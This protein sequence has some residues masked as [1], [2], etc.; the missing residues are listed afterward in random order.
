MTTA[1]AASPITVLLVEDNPGDARL[2]LELL[3][4]VQ[5]QAFDLERVERL[6]DALT[7]LSRTGV[8]VVLLDLGLPDSQGLETFMRA[9]RG[10]PDEPIVVISG[11]DDERLALEAVRSGAQDYLVKGRIEGHLL[12][13]VLRY[14]GV[15]SGWRR[16]DFADELNGTVSVCLRRDDLDL[17]F[18]TTVTR[19][20]APRAVASFSA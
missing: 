16:P 3:G 5:T 7:R 18:L 10:A 2:I 13:R 19:F 20:S 6:D 12:A 14:P 11:L 4:E 8:D 1:T 9:R 15:P 17:S